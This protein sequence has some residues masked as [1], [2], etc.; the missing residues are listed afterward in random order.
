MERSAHG[1]ETG[2]LPETA[3]GLCYCEARAGLIEECED[4]FG[5]RWMRSPLP[6]K[7]H[8]QALI[9]QENSTHEV[10]NA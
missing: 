5:G 3:E 1:K 8:G 9:T 2:A 7:R 6:Q 4:E 10:S